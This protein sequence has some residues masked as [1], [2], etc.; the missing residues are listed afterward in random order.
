MKSLLPILAHV[1]TAVLAIYW[2]RRTENKQNRYLYAALM[3]GGFIWSQLQ[4]E[5][6]I[7]RI[8]NNT[9]RSCK[10]N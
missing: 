3:I 7:W 10:K 6:L 4:T 5:Y 9:D 8:N 1:A 2:N